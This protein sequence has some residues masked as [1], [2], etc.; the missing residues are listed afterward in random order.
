VTGDLIPFSDY[1]ISNGVPFNLMTNGNLW[2]WDCFAPAS[3]AMTIALVIS[4]K[5]GTA[6]PSALLSLFS[7]H[8]LMC[9]IANEPTKEG[10]KQSHS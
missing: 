2:E 10:V 3:L 9:V 5:R 6:A 8:L 1:E 4:E 7:L